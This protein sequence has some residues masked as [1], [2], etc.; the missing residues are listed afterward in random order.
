LIPGISIGK[1]IRTEKR[2]AKVP[3]PGAYKKLP[4]DFPV[5]VVDKRKQKEQYEK[6]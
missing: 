5:H 6:N 2:D 3:G 4:T 1:G